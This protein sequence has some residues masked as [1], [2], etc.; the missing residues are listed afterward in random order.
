[1]KKSL[2]FVCRVF[3]ASTFSINLAYAQTVSVDAQHP[4]KSNPSLPLEIEQNLEALSSATQADPAS[5]E[6]FIDEV[7]VTAQRLR[8]GVLGN[9]EPVYTLNADSIDSYGAFSFEELLE[10]LEPLLGPSDRGGGG[11]PAVLVN[12]KRIS[13]FRE[14]ASYPP[15]ALRRVEILPEEVAL[16][17]GFQSN[18][19]VVNFILHDHFS[20]LTASARMRAATDGGQVRYRGEIGRLQI[21]R[22]RRFNLDLDYTHEDSLL[23]SER[24]IAIDDE[25]RGD[26]IGNVTGLNAGD[27]IDPALSALHGGLAT[28]AGAPDAAAVGPAALSGFIV[29]QANQ[30]DQTPFRTLR[31]AR[32]EASLTAT[33]TDRIFGSVSMTATATFDASRRES[34]LGLA[35]ADLVLPTTSVFSPFSN[36]VNVSRVFP[37]RGALQRTVDEWSG[38]ASLA[39]N[40]IMGDWNWWANGQYQRSVSET[41]TERGVNESALQDV[42]TSGVVNPFAPLDP[43]SFVRVDETIKQ[44]TNTTDFEVNVNGSLFALPA[45]DIT[46]AVSAGGQMVRQETSSSSNVETTNFSQDSGNVQISLSAPIFEPDVTPAPFGGVVL[47]A[48][49]RLDFRSNTDA[50]LTYEYGVFWSPTET[51]FLG[52]SVTHEAEAPSVQQT[53]AP[54]IRTPNSRVFDFSTGQ[55]VDNVAF[56][57]GGAPDLQNSD[58]RRFEATLNIRPFKK[59][60]FSLNATY[61]DQKIENQISAFPSLTPDTEAAFPDRFIRDANGALIEID[62]RAVNFNEA[63]RRDLRYGVDFVHRLK[64]SSSQPRRAR[65]NPAAM[66][67]R[68]SGPRRSM[69][70]VSVF[71]SY[72]LENSLQIN[73]DGQVLDLLAGD[74]IDV[75]GGVSRHEVTAQTRFSRKRLGARF[76]YTWQS[77]RTINDEDAGDLNFESLGKLNARMSWRFGSASNDSAKSSFLNNA[78]LSLRVN[79]VFNERQKVVDEN[80]ATPIRF[81]PELLDP[82]GRTISLIFRKRF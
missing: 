38:Q 28:I 43:G 53:D 27:E 57:R 76:D 2:L 61:S 19:R 34:L 23:E 64:S 73:E 8:G 70:G 7:V 72:A 22:N 20:A 77:A 32:D 29:G 35:D 25:V 10:G 9:T 24:N 21:N 55:T 40:G 15:E 69:I 4:S 12:G 58:L 16:Q 41:Q 49:S 37:E 82:Q 54:I 18:Q 60:Q 36:D 81:Q 31:P 63:T 67:G 17:Y 26:Q 14:I 59:R 42:V 51:V 47:N 80:G 11:R 44:T 52:A 65:R 46:A 48:S 62:A 75:N 78:R 71:H 30:T 50:L 66:F 33:F 45:G 74:S 79:N 13:D 1:M 39:F 3:G 6:G 56:L 5:E 68:R